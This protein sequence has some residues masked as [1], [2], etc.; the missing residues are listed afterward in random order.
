MNLKSEVSFILRTERGIKLRKILNIAF[1]VLVK[2]IN[3]K[4][5]FKIRKFDTLKVQKVVFININF[6]F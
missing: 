5:C 6:M 2:Y 1:G 3:K 4:N